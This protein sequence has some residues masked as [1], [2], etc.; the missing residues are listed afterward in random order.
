MTPDNQTGAAT[1]ST[2]PH[3][4]QLL[5]E[6]EPVTTGT[7]FLMLLFLMLIGGFWGLMYWILLHR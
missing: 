1:D 2:P 7:L 3:Q 6:G 4:T 5:S